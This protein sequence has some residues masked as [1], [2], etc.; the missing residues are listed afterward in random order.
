MPCVTQHI[1]GQ[2]LSAAWEDIINVDQMES[3]Q[4][5]LEEARRLAV[6]ARKYYTSVRIVKVGPGGTREV[7]A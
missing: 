1:D 3:D 2:D 4:A 6:E 5:E 7:V